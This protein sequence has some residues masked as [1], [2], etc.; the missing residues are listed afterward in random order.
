MWGSRLWQGIRF[1]DS[2][3]YDGFRY[4]I[5][6][7]MEQVHRCEL[8]SQGGCRNVL[9]PGKPVFSVCNRFLV[10]ND[11]KIVNVRGLLNSQVVCSL[12]GF[13]DCTVLMVSSTEIPKSLNSEQSCFSPVYS[14]LIKIPY[15]LAAL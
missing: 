11:H 14:V 6:K 12:G 2:E 5:G 3:G 9:E 13:R 7:A 15:T 8:G 1:V 4:D 10:R